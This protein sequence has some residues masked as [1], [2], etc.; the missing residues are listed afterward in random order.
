MEST[1]ISWV[2][3]QDSRQQRSFVDGKSPADM[4]IGY[5]DASKCE[6][7]VNDETAQHWT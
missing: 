3:W 7:Q 5:L 6:L 4:P 1:T 2:T